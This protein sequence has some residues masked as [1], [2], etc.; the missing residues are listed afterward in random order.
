MKR[1]GFAHD[2]A[3]RCE[4]ENELLHRYGCLEPIVEAPELV[5]LGVAN[6]VAHVTIRVKAR[7]KQ[8]RKIHIFTFNYIPPQ[9]R[10][11]DLHLR[12]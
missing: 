5:H 11:D 10:R 1:V 7:D 9:L 3:V 6:N 8:G 4:G 12:E 2:I